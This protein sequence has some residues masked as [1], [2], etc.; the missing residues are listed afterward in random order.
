LALAIKNIIIL[1]GFCNVK[2]TKIVAFVMAILFLVPLTTSCGKEDR[3]TLYVL[4]W[5]EY[6][7][8]ELIK[9]FEEQNPD[10]KI[11]YTTTTSNEEMYTICTT[12]GSKIDLLVP[13]DYMVERLISEDKLAEI[14]LDNIPNFKYVS[15]F[16]AT[17]AFDPESKYSI[18]NFIGTVGIIYNKNLVDEPVTSW[19]ILWDEKYSGKIMMYDSIRDSIMVALCKL[20][21]DINTTDPDELAEAGQLLIQQK[22]LIL[23]YGTDNIQY[24]MIG[25][26]VALAVDYSGSAAA[27]INQNSDLAYV[28]PDEGSN[29]W[30]DNYVILKN[31]EHK[32]AAERFIN[33]LCDPEISARNSE[34]VGYTTPNSAIDQYLD[35]A[36]LENSAYVIE[37]ETLNRCTYFK[38][39]G[40][41]ALS[42]WNDV[43]MEVKTAAK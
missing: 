11:N 40:T 23:A 10:I 25:G 12:E 18:P 4:N 3:T 36:M 37:A 19:D 33:F 29:V 43:W 21:Y 9:E 7:D 8:P 24:D 30:V 38:D 16:S 5:G 15:D 35:P 14:N 20:G 39:I 28:V 17:R 42:L 34:Y 27:A 26:S 2:I 41:D 32:E 6:L 13:S 31:S 22:P 1:G